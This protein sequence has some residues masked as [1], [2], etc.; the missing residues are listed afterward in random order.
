ML[1][2]YLFL[3]R[4]ELLKG[5]EELTFVDHAVIVGV[6]GSDGFFGLFDTNGGITVHIFVEIVEETGHFLGVEDS[7]FV[8]I[9]LLENRVDVVLEHLL[10]ERVQADLA[11]HLVFVILF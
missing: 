1:Q 11:L 3:L 9:V 8:S 10:L 2:S 5:R 6:D 4:H 7:I